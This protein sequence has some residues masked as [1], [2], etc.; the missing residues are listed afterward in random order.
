MPV[1]GKSLLD[2]PAVVCSQ[3]VCGECGHVQPHFIVEP[4]S[5][6]SWIPVM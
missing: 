3:F 2:S 4:A 5:I 1:E 6:G